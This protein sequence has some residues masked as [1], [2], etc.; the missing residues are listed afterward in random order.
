MEHILQICKT[1]VVQVITPYSSGSGFYLNEAGI[2]ITNFHVVRNCS[3]VIVFGTHFKKQLCRIKHLDPKND[4]AFIEPPE[5]VEFNAGKL[6]ETPVTDSEKIVAIGHPL[7]LE[8]TSTRGIVSKSSRLFNGIEYIQVDAAINPGNSGD[9]LINY[10]DEIVGVNT[11]I[12][13]DAENLGFALPSPKLKKLL[14]QYVTYGC[15]FSVKC[16]SCDKNITKEEAI[17][18]YCP[19]SGVKMYKE[20]FESEPYRSVGASKIVEQGLS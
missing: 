10:E 17:D 7:G 1:V 4:I 15:Y 12:Y 18:Y 3:E 8:Y 14:E 16:T 19:N 6:Q 13:R 20:D 11:F 9:P 2:I 5:N